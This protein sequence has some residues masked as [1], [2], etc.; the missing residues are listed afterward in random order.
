MSKF[1]IGVL[2]LS[3]TV[4]ADLFKEFDP[5][6]MIKGGLVSP[7][8]KN[9]FSYL[10]KEIDCG[11]LKLFGE[12]YK[13]YQYD[14]VAYP[15]IEKGSKSKLTDNAPQ[16]CRIYFENLLKLDQNA[17][18]NAYSL[19]KSFDYFL[20]DLVNK[21]YRN[22]FS[23]SIDSFAYKPSIQRYVFIDIKRLY[24]PPKLQKSSIDIQYKRHFRKTMAE[25]FFKS[26]VESKIP[27]TLSE[28]TIFSSNFANT[29][30]NNLVTFEKKTVQKKIVK[31]ILNT[32]VKKDRSDN[33][34]KLVLELKLQ[35]LSVSLGKEKRTFNFENPEAIFMLYLCR[36]KSSTDECINV[37]ETYLNNENNNFYIEDYLRYDVDIRES[38]YVEY[39]STKASKKIIEIFLVFVPKNYP[40]IVPRNYVFFKDKI[41]SNDEKNVIILCEN[42]SKKV[43]IGVA[44]TF[45]KEA[46]TFNADI[47]AIFIRGNEPINQISPSYLGGK[48][49]ACNQPNTKMFLIDGSDKHVM[50]LINEFSSALLVYSHVKTEKESQFLILK[51]CDF[52]QPENLLFLSEGK[53]I[54]TYNQKSVIFPSDVVL[55]YDDNTQAK[56]EYSCFNSRD[57]NLLEYKLKLD[58]QIVNFF[59]WN[60]NTNMDNTKQSVVYLN[61][62]NK[63]V[64]PGFRFSRFAWPKTNHNVIFISI[65]KKT[66]DSNYDIQAVYF[67]EKNELIEIF[68]SDKKE[69]SVSSSPQ[70]LL[71]DEED[72]NKKIKHVDEP[73]EKNDSVYL[74]GNEI[75]YQLEI[76][77]FQKCHPE[78]KIENKNNIRIICASCLL[79]CD[80]KKIETSSIS[81]NG[82]LKVINQSKLQSSENTEKTNN[83]ESSSVLQISNQVNESKK[84]ELKNERMVI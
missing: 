33:Q 24:V 26:I 68:S 80:G 32:F 50:I 11:K 69:I 81:R 41:D 1:L 75:V 58:R 15:K 10:Y 4:S 49:N 53:P 83:V 54:L 52:S 63:R 39:E 82:L 17:Y 60:F 79:S 76:S 40:G 20:I 3:F 18:W 74:S 57:S 64:D 73:I 44:S 37:N 59:I 8:S 6:P 13:N 38:S 30:N 66:S 19:V 48:F 2:I 9:V 46:Q 65:F 55:K 43:K 7:S 16:T 72:S 21:G 23:I 35:Q 22:P 56:I 14:Y 70:N 78:L 67:N 42:E 36:T 84:D 61:T 12:L 45:N 31:E 27:L 28:V 34:T 29:Y 62:S 77:N 47:N 25:A 71:Y 5:S 51:Q